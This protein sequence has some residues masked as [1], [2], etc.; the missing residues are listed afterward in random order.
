MNRLKILLAILLIGAAATVVGLAVFRD[1]KSSA[2]PASAPPR[3]AAKENGKTNNLAAAGKRDSRT[4][5]TSSLQAFRDRITKAKAEK[6]REKFMALLS[7]AV[8][9]LDPSQ[10]KE[11]LAEV[12]AMKDERFQTR[13]R[14]MLLSRWGESDPKAALTYIQGLNLDG[15]SF[16]FKV[17]KSVISS[18]AEKD[19]SAA[20]AWVEGLPP[21]T[22][23]RRSAMGDLAFGLA[24]KDPAAAVSLARSLPSDQGYE[25]LI[26]AIYAWCLKD[27]DTAI[28]YVAQLPAGAKKILTLQSMV[29]TL[30]KKDPDKA[31]TLLEQLPAGD[32]NNALCNI[33]RSWGRSDPKAALDWANQQTDPEV[34][35]QIL[36]GVI[37][38]MSVKDPN[39][40]PVCW[41]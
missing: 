6:D 36:R 13:L 34:K 2:V 18:W 15:G 12:E 7:E 19:F 16:P 10:I 24:Q 20:K 28:A 25:V 37:P 23:P 35:S 27:A 22:Y 8:Q 14:N 4:K 38:A 5:A 1:A 9:S 3:V 17:V 33:G 29:F 39:G 30:A 21:G 41:P 40:S 31:I 32:Q 26:Q 11:A